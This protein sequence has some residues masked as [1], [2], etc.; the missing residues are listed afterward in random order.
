MADKTP[1][2][3]TNE[4][5]QKVLRRITREVSGLVVADKV[6]KDGVKVFVKNGASVYNFKTCLVMVCNADKHP[7]R[8][9]FFAQLVDPSKFKGVGEWQKTGYKR[10]LYALNVTDDNIGSI[11]NLLKAAQP[12]VLKQPAAI[13]AIEAKGK[14]EE[15]LKQ[16]VTRKKTRADKAAEKLAKGAAREGKKEA[17]VTSP[18]AA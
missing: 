2:A 15:A 10:A 6:R 5:A 3:R 16:A 14:K 17:G 7:V 13:E 9:A 8:L 12:L 4:A 1:A 11:I 18:S